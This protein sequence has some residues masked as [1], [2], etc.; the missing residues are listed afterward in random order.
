MFVESP[1]HQARNNNYINIT[2]INETVQQPAEIIKYIGVIFV[3]RV[4]RLYT[5]T[6]H[7]CLT[8]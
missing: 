5:D 4:C 3:I 7:R 8:R 2:V 6:Q 1:V